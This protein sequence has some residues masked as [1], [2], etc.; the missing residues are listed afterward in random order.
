MSSSSITTAVPSGLVSDW[1]IQDSVDV[2]G[3][4]NVC[5]DS[6]KNPSDYGSICCAGDI[7]DTASDTYRYGNSNDTINLDTLVCCRIEGPQAQGGLQAIATDRNHCTQGDA[8][9]LASFAATNTANAALWE[10]T[11]TSAY[12]SVGPSTTVIG[13]YVPLQ[14]PMCLWVYTKAGVALRNVT[15]PAADITTPV[16]TTDAMGS[17]ITM[18]SSMS[19]S[20]VDSVTSMSSSAVDATTSA[21]GPSATSTSA[22]SSMTDATTSPTPASGAASAA[23]MNSAVYLL[24]LAFSFFGVARA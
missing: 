1:C 15:V 20:T 7:V 22:V 13:D 3:N 16:P 14:S 18:G 4:A 8:T 19:N 21:S 23:G 9:P 6:G 5:G 12:Q 17:T 10:K 11:L 24:L 2:E